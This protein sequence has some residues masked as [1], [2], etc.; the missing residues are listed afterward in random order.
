MGEALE[1]NATGN[2]LQPPIHIEE[3]AT[4]IRTNRT[5]V[6][7]P[8]PELGK[9][10]SSQNATKFGIFS[11]AILIKG[12]ANSDYRVLLDGLVESL[13]PDG[14]LEELL[15]DML[16]TI[17]WR[18]RRRLIAERAEVQKSTEF[19]REITQ[20]AQAGISVEMF[21]LTGSD[22]MISK[23]DDPNVFER[24]LELLS[25]LRQ[26]IYDRGF[27]EKSD[28]SLLDTIYGE[29]GTPR[30]RQFLH[31]EYSKWSY[32]ARATEDERVR[33]GYARPEQC[34]QYVLQAISAEIKY[35]KQDQVK[36]ESIKSKRKKVEALRQSVPDSPGLDRLLRYEASLDRAFDRTLS[37]LE[38]L[39]RIRKG[40][41][42]PPQLDVKIT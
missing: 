20:T 35:L 1:S 19:P 31:E 14:K 33:E 37:R 26:E 41:P 21:S 36:R 40:Q 16:A 28:R 24:C 2:A 23:M 5:A 7:G 27:D 4:Q 9:R 11:N 25:N 6:T 12:E 39:Q 13:Q 3:P 32:T 10:R 18:Y 34:K 22:A 15:V 29:P 38:R 17:L 30:T 42:L 8:R